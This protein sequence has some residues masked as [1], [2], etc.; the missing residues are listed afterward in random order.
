M[1][2][3]P[4]V[5]EKWAR[6]VYFKVNSLT[7]TG[8]PTKQFNSDTNCPALAQ[9]KGPRPRRLLPFPT[10]TASP[11]CYNHPPTPPYFCP[12]GYKFRASTAL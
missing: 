4:F 3:I 5:K 6:V 11:G 8:C 2:S 10:P 7:P 1:T 12:A 9:V